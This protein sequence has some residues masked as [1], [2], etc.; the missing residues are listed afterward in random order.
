MPQKK[1]FEAQGSPP[2]SDWDSLELSQVPEC[3]LKAYNFWVGFFFTKSEVTFFTP[4]L[5][6]MSA[7]DVGR[8]RWPLQGLKHPLGSSRVQP[9]RSTPWG[10]IYRFQIHSK[11]RPTASLLPRSVTISTHCNPYMPIPCEARCI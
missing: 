11:C 5:I 9:V 6:L 8:H 2:D 1:H 7:E 4:M 3:L 10:R